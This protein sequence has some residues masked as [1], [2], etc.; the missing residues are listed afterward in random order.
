MQ[1]RAFVGVEYSNKEDPRGIHTLRKI[2]AAKKI[3]RA[4][5]T[6]Y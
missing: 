1:S 5:H 3:C 2:I 4:E 6:Y